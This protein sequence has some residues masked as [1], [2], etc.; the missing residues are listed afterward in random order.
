MA[1]A[2]R[3]FTNPLP[4][5]VSRQVT[6][7]RRY[8]LSLQPDR[9]AALQ[10]VCGGVERMSTDYLVDR[11]DFP[12]YAVELVTEGEGTLLINETE[13]R[14]S[15]G[16]VFAYG[17]DSPHTI[18]NRSTHGMR[19]YYVDFVGT[20]SQRRLREVGLIVG[21]RGK[22]AYTRMSVAGFHQLA[23]LF[24]LMIRDATQ[25]ST[26][27][28]SIAVAQLNLILLKLQQLRVP[29]VDGPP[30]SYATFERVRQH[31]DEHFLTIRSAQQLATRCDVTPV[32]LSRLFSRF[33]DCGAYQYLMRSKMNFAAGL[34]MNDGLLVKE[35]AHRMGFRDAFQFSRAFKRVYGVAPVR[36]TDRT[37]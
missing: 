29:N 13:H 11:R 26:L 36:L 19:K 17:P 3:E 22:P 27:N 8:F 14:L 37:A 23:E 5:F 28:D 21:P 20:R 12:Y 2:D 9:K 4:S 34:L 18:Q 30:A 1:N 15:P 7:A 35:V 16:S 25:T 32:H 33:A 24:E 6:D 10:V 31:V